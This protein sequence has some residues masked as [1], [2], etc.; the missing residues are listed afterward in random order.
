VTWNTVLFDLDGT[1]TESG[2]GVANGVLHALAAF[3]LPAPSEQELRKYLGPPL[4]VSFDEF[5]GLKGDDIELAV[6]IYREY[7]HDK[8]RF[9]NA[10]YQGIPELLTDLANQNVRLAV[11]TSKVDHSAVS[12]LDHFNLSS[13]FEVIAGSDELGVSR[14]TKAKVIAHA[15]AQLH[16]DSPAGVVMIG[17]REHD[18][19]GASEHGLE[20][21][22]VLWGYG[23][24]AELTAA[25]AGYITE[26]VTDLRNLLLSD[27]LDN[28]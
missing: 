22:G 1:L 24:V 4:W 20:N 11:A 10:V 2:Q 3:D 15:L 19:H 18:I 7:Y 8:G 23:D 26:T 6:K 28:L 12:I 14:G 27:S 16:I 25:G 5:A 9:E 21:I 17:D 13:H